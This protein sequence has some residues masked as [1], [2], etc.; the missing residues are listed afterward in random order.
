V[1]GSK[2]GGVSQ[3]V[4]SSSLPS[5]AR[6]DLRLD[7]YDC[8]HYRRRSGIGLELRTAGAAVFLLDF[9]DEKVD[10]AARDLGAGAVACNVSS[11]E[12]VARRPRTR[13]WPG[14]R[15]GAN[16]ISPSAVTQMTASIADEKKS[17]LS[18]AIP[19][20]LHHRDSAA[21]RRWALGVTALS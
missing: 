4:K 19:L 14:S 18:A 16:A 6:S 2:V 7:R 1:I 10:R 3:V 9:D 17:E 15:Q 5:H 12:S 13:S 11:T 20:G 21:S 8:D